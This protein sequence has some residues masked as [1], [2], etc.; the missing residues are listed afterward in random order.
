MRVVQV[1]ID[2]I[3]H[4]VSVRHRWVTAARPMNVIRSV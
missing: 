1:A 4:M 2:Q 3:V